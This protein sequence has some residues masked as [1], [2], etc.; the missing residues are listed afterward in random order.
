MGGG[1]GYLNLPPHLPTYARATCKFRRDFDAPKGPLVR[2]PRPR[3]RA[4]YT[5]ETIRTAVDPWAFIPLFV[6]LGH[7]NM[8]NQGWPHVNAR[9][10]P[11]Q[12]TFEL[13]ATCQEPFLADIA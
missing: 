4:V 8:H 1:I 6:S 3:A 5:S 9:F 12:P 13:P 2:N 7:S 11:V 10:P